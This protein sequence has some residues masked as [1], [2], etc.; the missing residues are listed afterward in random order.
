MF[1]PRVQEKITDNFLLL[2]QRLTASL[3][4]VSRINDFF[5]EEFSVL[6]LHSQL[7][8]GFILQKCNFL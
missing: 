4:I 2:A 7:K 5:Y 3:I 8:E 1:Y 6:T